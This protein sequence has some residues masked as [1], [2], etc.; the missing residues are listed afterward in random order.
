MPG[1]ENREICRFDVVVVSGRENAHAF[2]LP[3]TTTTVTHPQGAGG[4][5]ATLPFQPSSFIPASL[6]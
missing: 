2:S 5:K 4:A 3:D 1:K 6:E